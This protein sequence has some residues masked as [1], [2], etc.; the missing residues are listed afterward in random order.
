MDLDVLLETLLVRFFWLIVNN[1][2]FC[3]ATLSLPH[4]THFQGHC[5]SDFSRARHRLHRLGFVLVT[6]HFSF[7]SYRF[8]GLIEESNDWNQWFHES[9]E[10]GRGSGEGDDLVQSS[11]V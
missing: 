1:F 4:F 11:V 10:A 9:L 6:E 3:V 5:W 2:C 7:L 8:F